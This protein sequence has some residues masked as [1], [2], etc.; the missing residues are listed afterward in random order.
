M[1]NNYQLI[2][3]KLGEEKYRLFD[4]LPQRLYPNSSPRF[5]LGHEPVSLHL[6]GLY[7]LMHA[8]N[9]V[10]RFAFYENPK[11]CYQKQ[12][13]ACIGSYECVEDLSV[14]K[15]LL[16]KAKS[17]ARERGYAWLIG[18]MEGS[19]WNSY[20]FSNN[21]D[22]PNFFMEPYH[23]LYYN[24][25][26]LQ[27][28]FN[29]IGEYVSN[30]DEG[31]NFDPD[32]LRDF[33]GKAKDRGLSFRNLDV[34][35]LESE[36]ERIADFSIEAFKE[37][38]LYTPIEREVFVAKYGKLTDLFDPRLVLIIEDAEGELQA[39]SFSIPDYCDSQRETIIVKSIAKRSGF[40]VK[41]IGRYLVGITHERAY[42]LGFR[43]AIHAFMHMTNS[44]LK[45]SGAEFSGKAYKTYTLYG[46]RL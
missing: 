20:R 30:V 33:E 8:D 3:T 2:Q 1:R 19:T 25:Q 15:E 5:T 28:G 32:Y 21:N 24:E 29:S 14:S 35:N 43:K 12:A 41:G 27:A 16:D 9:P 7:V 45:V 34:E 42:S 10:G 44:S 26:F 39:L 11:L 4:Q 31:L 6:E 18:P 36:L 13:A 37:N 17:M 40:P 23:H 22:E 38:F 46:C